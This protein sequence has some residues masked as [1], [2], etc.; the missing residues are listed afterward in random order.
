[1]PKPKL[2]ALL[3][4]AALLPA[5]SRAQALPDLKS[6]DTLGQSLLERSGSTGL[7]LVVVRDKE[8][9]VHG[10]GETAPG[11]HQAPT[12]TSLLRLC[13][14]TKI[15][16][17]DLLIK[18]V[19][20][21][22]VRLDD[23]LKSYA[24]VNATVPDKQARPITLGDLATHTAGLPREMAPTPRGSGHFTFPNHAQRWNWLPTAHL[25]TVPGTAALYSNLS[26]DLLG[27]A[28]QSAAQMPYAAL[29][30]AR[31][32][33]PLAMWETNYTPTP[34]QCARLLQ[35]V[36][37]E[38]Q[39]TDTQATAGSSGL[40]STPT[41]ISHWLQYLL[42]QQVGITP[43]QNPA[44]QAVYL[45]PSQLA[46]IS[47]LDHAGE[48][49]GIGLGWI[50]TPGSLDPTATDSEIIEKTGGGAGFLTYI[51]INQSRHTAIFV[52]A[53]D[54]LPETHL[55]LFKAANNVLLTLAGLPPLPEAPPIY[56]P[57]SKPKRAAHKAATHRRL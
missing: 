15:F 25:I 42:G 56:H 9:Y 36:H 24:P 17:A 5:L 45:Q 54:G 27:D 43:G 10:F 19:Q 44:A 57:A 41:D 23:P 4:L 39:C 37:D 46:S 38:G 31:T 12:A 52:A 11:S 8:I 28:L 30:R 34:A 40:Y 1:M 21:K 33:K 50:H 35:G 7:V 26:F 48:A 55:N 13:S 2:I 14:L 49:T 20:D 51:A 29:L 53:T 47:G 32:L 16:A 6:A 3:A 22:T 18:L